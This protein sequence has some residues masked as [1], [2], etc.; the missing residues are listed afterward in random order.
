MC[1][2]DLVIW[3]PAIFSSLF[4]VSIDTSVGLVLSQKSSF[5]GC[6]PNILS[7]VHDWKSEAKDSNTGGT[8]GVHV[9]DTTTKEDS[10]AP[11]G[12]AILGAQV[13]KTNQAPSRPSRTVDE[14]LGAHPVNDDF[15]G[16]TNPT[17]VSIDTATSE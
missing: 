6:A 10:T 8:T 12:E 16:N 14:I 15:W 5:T 17:D 11:S 1:V 3:L 7:T 9:E 2:G 4:T 13:F